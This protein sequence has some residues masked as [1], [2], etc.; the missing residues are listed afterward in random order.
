MDTQR[1]GLL[2]KLAQEYLELENFLQDSASMRKKLG[3]MK[4]QGSLDAGKRDIYKLRQLEG[5]LEITN[6]NVRLCEARIER[7]RIE[8]ELIA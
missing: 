6:L 7:F 5:E 1:K 3:Q 4:H 2:E 8:I